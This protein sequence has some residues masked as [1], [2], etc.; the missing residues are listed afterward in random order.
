VSARLAPAAVASSRRADKDA[1]WKNNYS[2]Q[3]YVDRDAAYAT[4]QP[5]YRTGFEGRR[6][7]PGK[8]FE[9]VEADLQRD[10]ENSKGSDVEL[11]QSPARSARRLASGGKS[12]A[13]RR[14]RKWA[15]A[16]Q[17]CDAVTLSNLYLFSEL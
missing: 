16:C 12:P 11:G 17:L 9:E 8:K 14:G 13:R 15:R 10:H 7:Y 6:Q 5:A 1:Y 4:Y 2:R 3:S